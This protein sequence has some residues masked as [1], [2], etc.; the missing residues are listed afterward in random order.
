MGKIHQLSTLLSNQIA[1]GEVIERPASVVKELVENAV[2]AGAT[3]VQVFLT[4]AGLKQVQVIDNGSG[5]APD[6]LEIAFRRH[7]TSKINSREDLFRVHSL[8]FRGEA[9]AS[10]ASVAKVQLK[11][12]TGGVNTGREMNITADETPTIKLASHPQGTTITVNDLFYNTPARLKYMKSQT[13]ELRHSADFMN[14]VVLS[15]PKVAFTLIN[16]GHQLVLSAG[17][18]NLQQAIAGIYGASVAQELLPISND[19]L[20]FKVNGFISRPAVTR[21]SNNYISFLI[22]GRYIKNYALTKA[23]IQGYGTKLMVGRYPVA[24]IQL[25]MDP[26][27][28]DVNVHP[29]KKEV[30][31]SKEPELTELVETTVR[32]ALA[33]QNLIPDALTNLASH[34]PKVDFNKLSTDLA[35]A[36][37]Q[38]QQPVPP[39]ATTTH[40]NAPAN[41]VIDY[42]TAANPE[43]SATNSTPAAD[44][45]AEN[46]SPEKSAN[47]EATD[48]AATSAVATNASDNAD[49]L[50][51]LTEAP[52]VENPF[53]DQPVLQAWDQWL[54]QDAKPRPFNQPK[55]VEKPAPEVATKTEQTGLFEN[56]TSAP[57]TTAAP[58]RFPELRY[59]GQI[60][61]TYL[62]AESDDGFYLLDQHAAQERVKYE[63]LR[64]TI[65]QVTADQ[66]N[67]LV[68]LVLTYSVSDYLI[69]KEHLPLLADVGLQL[70]EFGDNTFILHSH[71]TWF[72]AGQEEAMVREMIDYFLTD[73]KISV[74]K[75]REKTA[76]MAACKGSIKANHHMEPEQ[77]KQLLHDLAQTENPFNCPHGRPVLVHYS[78]Q[79]LERMFKR[80][81]DSHHSWQG[82][83]YQ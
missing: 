1:A 41:S 40:V 79:D 5:F 83:S 74:A 7:T 10:I 68:P 66:Q 50:T 73:G 55:P 21:S 38:A 30:R 72:K 51:A 82:E 8:G 4:D 48:P 36:S 24:I 28:V 29:T 3:K 46:S 35:Q 64:V 12:S 70:E 20:D 58:V 65:G 14:R 57:G 78:N 39:A 59:L 31:L 47:P 11:T 2:D 45:I 77:A 80:I 63:Q 33:A 53:K 71:P 18:G 37:H 44:T 19:D 81:Q 16:N 32:Q 49:E 76:I 6:D 23:L 60:H 15:Y 62:I 75:F 42:T 52:L 13:T 22:N 26:L 54:A 69:I 34:Q 61:G 27:L 17:N 43:N 9:L 25:T 67:L 56:E